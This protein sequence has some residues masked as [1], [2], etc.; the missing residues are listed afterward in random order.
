MAPHLQ[1]SLQSR[2]GRHTPQGYTGKE[3]EAELPDTVRGNKIKHMKK[4]ETTRE[5]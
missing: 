3:L 5:I 2:E 4:K 1:F